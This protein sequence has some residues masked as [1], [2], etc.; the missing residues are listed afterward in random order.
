MD[1]DDFLKKVNQQSQG[2]TYE[3]ELTPVME[4][5]PAYYK[6]LS[7]QVN[8]GKVEHPLNHWGDTY[9]YLVQL[10]NK[11]I[12]YIRTEESIEVHHIDINE[13]SDEIID[14][15]MV[16]SNRAPHSENKQE[17]FTLLTLESYLPYLLQG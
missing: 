12:K 2:R 16:T 4:E 14:R 7:S 9:E 1:R 13:S 10:N 5:L 8:K 11:M 17:V 15:I 6:N 3:G